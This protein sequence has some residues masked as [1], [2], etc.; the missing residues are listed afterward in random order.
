MGQDVIY[1]KIRLFQIIRAVED[2]LRGG[3]FLLPPAD[4]LG[5]EGVVGT[6]PSAEN[7]VRVPLDLIDFSPHQMQHVLADLLH[8]AAV[9]LRYGVLLKQGEVFV[10]KPSR[11][12]TV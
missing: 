6:F 7:K 5:A 10:L 11:N 8:L 12:A 3:H 4:P 2:L 9:P 1:L